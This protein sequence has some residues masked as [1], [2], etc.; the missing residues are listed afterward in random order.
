M[1]QCPAEIDQSVLDFEALKARCLGNLSLVERILSKF[2]GQLDVDLG[3]LQRA[4][5]TGDAVQAAEL[6]HR[7]KGTAGSVAARNLYED[8]SRAEQR[9]RDSQFAD[10]AADLKRMRNDRSELVETI[11]RMKQ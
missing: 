8:A 7:I 6:T 9:A 2:T 4:I 11:D 10:L 1:N 3:Q 5:E